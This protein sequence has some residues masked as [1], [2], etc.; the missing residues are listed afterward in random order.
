MA[1]P[2]KNAM[3]ALLMFGT[4]TVWLNFQLF[5]SKGDNLMPEWTPTP[6]VAQ[7]DYRPECTDPKYASITQSKFN[8]TNRVVYNYMKNTK[9]FILSLPRSGSSFFGEMFM[10][11]PDFVYIYEMTREIVNSEECATTLDS[12]HTEIMRNVFHCDF[13]GAALRLDKTTDPRASWWRAMQYSSKNAGLCFPNDTDSVET[14][15]QRTHQNIVLKEIFVWGP[16][17]NWLYNSVAKDLKLIW[18][19]RDV[20]GWVSSFL[21]PEPNTKSDSIY[22]G[23][24]WDS[25]NLWKDYRNCEALD[26]LPPERRRLYEALMTNFSTPVHE[27]LAA[28]WAVD[29]ALTKI[30]LEESHGKYFLVQ[31]E[32][33]TMYTLGVTQQ[34]YNFVGAPL[35]SKVLQW[36]HNSTKQGNEKDR[37]SHSRDATQMASVWTKRLSL[38]QILDIEEIAGDLFPFFGYTPILDVL[39]AHQH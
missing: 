5:K 24:D 1:L 20:R 6:A 17:I 3:V 38:Q 8:S 7:K 12:K 19:V 33:L 32:H 34:T 35:P 31:Y 4:F 22:E 13:R 25:I 27:R 36:M 23:W 39:K 37:Y 26:K 11:N 15:E 9:V 2:L 18:I 28:L 21:Q 29:T 30:Y 10:Q 14:I 16:K